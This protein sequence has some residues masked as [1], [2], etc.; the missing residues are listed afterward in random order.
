MALTILQNIILGIIQGVAEWLPVSSS[1]MI[2]LVNS[3]FFGT[4]ELDKLLHIALFL[5]LGTFFSALV[6]F[7]KEVWSLTKS[8]FQYKYSEEK[9]KKTLKFLIISTIISGIIGLVILFILESLPESINL[10]GKIITFFVAILLLSSGI[11]QLK[12]KNKGRRTEREIKNSDSILLG[13]MQ[14]I[15]TLPGISRSGITVSSLLLNNFDDTTAIRLSFLM[16]LPIVLISNIILNI[17]DF[18]KAITLSSLYGVL[19]SFTFG[20]LTIHTMMKIS[21]K[22]N[23]GWF[24]VIFSI[25]MGISLLI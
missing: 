16:S 20:I 4:T 22:I 5:H 3:N 13:A 9:T 10:T 17:P 24:L 7:H 23:F 15:S 2:T 14:G 6:Y 25:L 18:G 12:A 1:G 21:K 19:A 11:L 8:L